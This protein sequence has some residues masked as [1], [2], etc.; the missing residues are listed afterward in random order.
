MGRLQTERYCLIVDGRFIKSPT[1][2]YKGLGGCSNPNP[3][4]G[5]HAN[6]L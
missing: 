4:L 6:S 1:F 3:F 2:T 5:G